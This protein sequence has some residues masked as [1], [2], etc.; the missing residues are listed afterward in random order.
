LE[1]AYEYNNL[2]T[3]YSCIDDY[4]NAQRYYQKALQMSAA[5]KPLQAR[6]TY[7]IGSNLLEL[8]QQ[9][10]AVVY[11]RQSLQLLDKCG[12]NDEVIIDYINNYHSI[13]DCY[14]LQGQLDSAL[15]Y[16]RRCMQIN[17]G[18]EYRQG[19]TYL[20]F[21]EIYLKRKKFDLA[22]QAIQ[23]SLHCLQQTYG[24][25]SEY[26]AGAY[27][28]Y[29][30]IFSQKGQL[31][32]GIEYLQKALASISIQF[33]DPKGYSN[34]LLDN[35]QDKGKLI[36]LLR[37]KLALMQQVYHQDTS[38]VQARQIFECALLATQALTEHNRSM[39]HEGSKINLLDKTSLGLYEESIKVALELFEYSQDSAYLDAAFQFSEQSKSMLMTD[40]WHESD[41]TTRSIPKELQEKEY[42]LRSKL[43]HYQKLRFEANADSN[44]VAAQQLDE[45]CF[46]LKH[47]LD[48]LVHLFEA[49]YPQY[50]AIKYSRETIGMR[51]IQAVLPA[52]AQMIEFFEGQKD[53]YIF[54]INK[55][56]VA[57]TK[58]PIDANYR[59][60]INRFQQAVTDIQVVNDNPAEMHHKLS[61]SGL[62]LFNT[63]LKDKLN[64]T[65][66][67]LIVIP[68][69]ALNLIPF[70]ALVDQS[71]PAVAQNSR[72]IHFGG[73][74]Y[75]LKNYTISYNYSAD[76]LRRQLSKLPSQKNMEILAL[77][78]GYNQYMSTA[79]RTGDNVRDNLAM[80]P[81][82]IREVRFLQDHFSGEYL[83]KKAANE[84]AFK[85]AAPH[86]D[87]IH[88]AMHGLVD[89]Q[90]PQFSSLV[91]DK[92]SLSEEDDILYAYEIQNLQLN[93]DLVV[94][95]AC[96]T[97]VGKFQQGEGVLSIGRGF[98]YAGTSSLVMTL[99]GL[100][101][102]S[103]SEIIENYYQFL[104]K[105]MDKDE[106]LKKAKLDYIQEN[107][108]LLSH[109]ALWACY[110]QMGNTDPISIKP[111]L[112]DSKWMQYLGILLAGIFLSLGLRHY[113]Q[114][115]S[116][117]T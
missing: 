2:A 108:G 100:N 20:S 10:S 90:N 106:A 92:D 66:K 101:D 87:I 97:G 111:N 94:L 116:N 65:I 27:S 26:M 79:L 89:N 88:L 1:L 53:L 29:S 41:A 14:I 60:Q 80:L 51:E 15:S 16:S 40:T 8:Y 99:W 78:P 22:E 17:T 63:L 105:G 98:M 59:V 45:R 96:E 73:L 74:P 24:A 32:L 43:M 38:L 77:A 71:I 81:G 68:D 84:Q 67:R 102:Y 83:Y 103:G 109:P 30:T 39:K 72:N 112:G 23:K 44:L 6:I 48:E 104:T 33:S 69:G 36:E 4:S 114:S 12:K 75:L 13:I 85:D 70:E 42:D 113:L 76:L 57:C 37:K 5:D 110:I 86:F 25:K 91:L 31:N 82:A 61:E 28:I 52:N 46:A 64:P 7:N 11:F 62:Y 58:I 54:S 55:T 56:A 34:P 35:V 19:F 115:S 47:K 117:H 107:S 21:A 49:A 18:F 3:T 95:S 50:F 93:P 9:D